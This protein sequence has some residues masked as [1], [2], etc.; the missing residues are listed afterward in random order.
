MAGW[1]EYCSLECI[2]CC[3]GLKLLFNGSHLVSSTFHPDINKTLNVESI[4]AAGN[5]TWLNFKCP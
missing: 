4:H 3:V 1:L 2:C 5:I